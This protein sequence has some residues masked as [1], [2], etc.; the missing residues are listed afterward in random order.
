[1]AFGRW[2]A[3]LKVDH[4]DLHYGMRVVIFTDIWTEITDLAVL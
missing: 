2:E 4:A 3:V 1:M